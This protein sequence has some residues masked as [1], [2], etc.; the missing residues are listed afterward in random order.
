MA[1]SQLKPTKVHMLRDGTQ[2][3]SKWQ[4]EFL[5]VDSWILDSRW[6]TDM[7]RL[8]KTQPE[9][10]KFDSRRHR[11]NAKTP[12]YDGSLAA[13]EITTDKR[14]DTVNENCHVATNDFT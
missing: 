9:L 13:K 10:F 14:A 1:V 5:T 6:E 7:S 8:T 2:V 3:K 4:I 12:A 11:C